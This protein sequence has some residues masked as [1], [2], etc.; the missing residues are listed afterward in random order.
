MSVET[1]EPKRWSAGGFTDGARRD[2]GALFDQARDADMAK[3]ALAPVPGPGF[4][5][6]WLQPRRVAVAVA[7]VLF[8]GSVGGVSG[9]QLL[10]ALFG[11]APVTAPAAT[12]GDPEPD[13]WMR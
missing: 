12:V 8:L 11:T 5:A 6:L 10:R 3:A 2:L 9:G 1:Q 4:W 13:A 7:L